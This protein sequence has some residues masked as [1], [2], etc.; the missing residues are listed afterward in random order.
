MPATAESKCHTYTLYQNKVMEGQGTSSVVDGQVNK[1]MEISEQREMTEVQESEDEDEDEE[2]QQ[3]QQEMDI[4][5]V[6]GIDIEPVEEGTV[7]VNMVGLESPTTT[8]LED[9][10]GWPAW[11]ADAVDLMHDGECGRQ[12]EEILIKLVR[13]ERALGFKGEK[14]VSLCCIYQKATTHLKI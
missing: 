10:V 11:L 4:E 6:S 5:C 2:E 14:T 3:Q 9:R 7:Q 8:E 13:I 1:R 12:F